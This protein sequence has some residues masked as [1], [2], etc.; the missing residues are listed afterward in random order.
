[1]GQ[2][3]ERPSTMGVR[4]EGRLGLVRAGWGAA[5][6]LRNPLT[7]GVRCGRVVLGDWSNLRREP[8]SYAEAWTGVVGEVLEQQWWAVVVGAGR[9]EER[10]DIFPNHSRL[11]R[12]NGRGPVIE[13]GQ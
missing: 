4:W 8:A 7:V 12:W 13:A 11:V 2:L 9:T 1:M 6:L 5:V 10:S 3:G